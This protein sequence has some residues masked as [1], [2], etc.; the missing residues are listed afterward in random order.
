MRLGGP[1]FASC[2]GPEQWIAE[3]RRLGYSAAYCPVDERA[4]DATVRAYGEAAGQAGIVIAEV[5]IWNNPLSTDEAA[6]RQAVERCVARLDLA[7][8][9]GAGCTVNI[10]GSLGP[11]WD[12]PFAADLTEDAFALIVESVRRIL[13][14]ARPKRTFYT[15]EAMPWMY[16]ESPEDYLRLLRAIDRKSFAVHLDPVNWINSPPRFLHNA[17][18]VREMYRLLGPYVK[19][20]H[21]KD[22]RL[23]AGFTALV[24]EVRPGLGSLDYQTLL[25]ESERLSP[26]LPLMLEHLKTAEEYDQAA[27]YVRQQASQAGIAI[28]LPTQAR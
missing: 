23:N 26:D 14:A 24:E 9:I 15:L 22:T 1:V 10:A 8:R 13:D 20:V 28:R 16:P 5:G 3:L 17:A 19:A 6:R 25:T 12:G 2:D 18:F 21:I 27:A 7:D 11:K 4:D